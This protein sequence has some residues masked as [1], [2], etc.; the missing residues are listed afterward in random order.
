MPRFCTNFLGNRFPLSC[1]GIVAAGILLLPGCADLR[2]SSVDEPLTSPLEGSLP[3]YWGD[4]STTRPLPASGWLADFQSPDLE[5]LAKTALEANPSLRAA[6]ARVA[7]ARAR[8]GISSSGLLP[9]IGATGSGSESQRVLGAQQSNVLTQSYALGWDTSWEL[10]LWGRLRDERDSSLAELDGAHEDYRAARLS[11]VAS[12]AKSALDLLELEKQ[13]QLSRRNVE[14]LQLSLAIIDD[15]LERGLDNTGRLGLDFSLARADLA[16]G[17]ATLQQRERQIESARRSLETLLGEYPDGDASPLEDFPRMTRKVPAG[18]PAELLLRRPDLL[19]AERRADASGL[20]VLAA[21][22]ALLPSLSL[23]GSRGQSTT[24]FGRLLDGSSL[25]WSIGT[26]ISQQI[27]AG[28]QLVSGIRLAEAQQQEIAARYADAALLAF[29]QVETGL[30]IEPLIA[31]Q[32]ELLEQASKESALAADLARSSYE[33]GLADILTVLE[34]QRRAVD[35]ESALLAL[36]NLQ[37]QTRIDLHL[38]LGGG[39]DDA[40]EPVRY[41]RPQTRARHPQLPGRRSL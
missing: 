5:R 8:S 26:R 17:E 23:T 32:L 34:S 35:A 30:A 37:L 20:D 13:T 15:N 27:F 6:A 33:Q 22:K 31:R 2:R 29:R 28:G 7:A 1:S 11:L 14:R 25:V 12:V 40:P 38:A 21:R 9:R 18:L 36:R 3:R 39:F 16:R 19:A 4:D 41:V 24:D 10:D